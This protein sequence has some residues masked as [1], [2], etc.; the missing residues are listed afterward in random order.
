MFEFSTTDTKMF[1]SPPLVRERQFQK[2]LKYGPDY[3]ELN[4]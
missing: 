4:Y 1:N 3:Y 2:S